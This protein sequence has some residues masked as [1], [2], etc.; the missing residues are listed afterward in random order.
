METEVFKEKTTDYL[1]KLAET[2]EAIRKMYFFDPEH[3]SI[4]PD[5]E[6][7][8]LVEKKNTIVK[9]LINK[10]GN[11]AIIL[12]SYTC[13]ANCRFCER[14]DRVGVGL[15]S[16]GRL[17]EVEIRKAVEVI[18]QDPN[19]KE[20]I[21]SGGDPLTNVRG[22]ELACNLLKE[23]EHVKI[24]RIHTKLPMQ[25]PD[26]VDLELLSRLVSAKDTFYFSVHVNHPDELNE[27]TLPILSKIRKQG[28]V[29]ISQSVFLK[30]VNDDVE[31]LEKLYSTL[32]E[33][34]I[35]PYYIY[36]CQ[37][38]PTTKRFVI[39]IEREVE[40]MTQL[41]EKLSGLAWPQH[42]VDLQGTTGKVIVP[43]NHWNTDLSQCRD[44]FGNTISPV[45]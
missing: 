23:V 33:N 29:M 30:E 24:L 31:V 5:L 14:Q 9:G 6:R 19:I 34:G 15:D 39:G 41:R 20:V 1:R 8:L 37:E 44:Y 27:V 16:V 43:T 2:S 7:D 28:Y 18:A 36:H 12:L 17:H 25:R 3:E 40:L 13:A 35:R 26:H 22:L 4:P 32:A 11:R 42:V 45:K 10:F 38:I 21:F